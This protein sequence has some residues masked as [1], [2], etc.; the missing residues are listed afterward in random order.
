MNAL[1]NGGTAG[2]FDAGK[3]PAQRLR[4]QSDELEK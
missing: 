3:A 2:D 4:T 1:V